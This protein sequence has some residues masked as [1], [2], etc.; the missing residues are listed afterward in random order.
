[1]TDAGTDRFDA[2]EERVSVAIHTHLANLQD[3]AAGFALLPQ[4]VPRAAEEDHFSGALSLG[5]RFWIHEGKHQHVTGALVL[6]DGRYQSTAFLKVDL[7]CVVSRKKDSE[8]KNPA[9][10]FCASGL[11]SALFSDSLCPPQ[12]ARRVAVMMV[13]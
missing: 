11:K 10:A 1:M 6:D 3:V 12:A 4:L 5:E 7:H 13:V 9:G 2:H 8:N